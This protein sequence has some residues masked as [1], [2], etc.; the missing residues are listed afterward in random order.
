MQNFI[1][2]EM[3][4]NSTDLRSEFSIDLTCLTA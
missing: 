2:N 3:P 1:C 4:L